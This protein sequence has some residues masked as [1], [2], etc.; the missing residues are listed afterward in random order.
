MNISFSNK[1]LKAKPSG[2]ELSKYFGKKG[3]SSRIQFKTVE[4]QVED[5]ETIIANG[6]TL[7]YQYKEDNVMEDRK[8]NYIGTDFI[9]IDIDSTDLT[10]DEVI[11]KATYKPT[12]IHTTFSNLTE[13]KNNKYCYHLLYCLDETLFGEENFNYAFSYFSSGIEDLVDQKAKDCHRI[14]FTSNSSLPNYEYRLLGDTYPTS[15]I[16]NNTNYSETIYGKEVRQ[17]ELSDLLATKGGITNEYNKYKSSMSYSSNKESDFYVNKINSS[18]IFYSSYNMKEEDKNLTDK[19]GD[20]GLN[21]KFIYDLSKMNRKEFIC[22]YSEVYDYITFTPPTITRKTEEGIVYADYRNVEYYELP[23]LWRINDSGERERK[24]IEIGGRTTQLYVD[25][26]LFLLI[27]PDITKEHLVYEVV[28][29]VFENYK[30]TDRQFTNHYILSMINNVWKKKNEFIGHPIPKKFKI[31]RYADGMTQMACIG[32]VRK[33]MKDD[34]I[35]SVIDINLSIEENLVE[36]GKMGMKIKKNR[37]MQFIKDNNLENYIRSDK[38]IKAERV[39]DIV[40][41]NPNASLRKLAE[42]CKEQ[43]ILVSYETIR[44][45]SRT[46]KND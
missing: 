9:I 45:I 1:K 3:T 16:I 12:I 37:L 24:K 15:I 30:N 27:K 32:I 19:K 11:D 33:L 4:C 21:K 34:S 10:I 20:W 29:D 2:M 18:S 26:N 36:F 41:A 46:M 5:I 38:Q 44:K 25:I 31:L 39:L 13:K 43:N 7:A 6:H 22:T 42:M 35:G 23:S 8:K 14:T 40:K 17:A 28:K